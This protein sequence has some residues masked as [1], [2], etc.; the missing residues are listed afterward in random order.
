MDKHQEKIRNLPKF[1][2]AYLAS[3]TG[4]RAMNRQPSFIEKSGKNSKK[5]PIKWREFAGSNQMVEAFA[6]AVNFQPA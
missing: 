6:K 2:R 5:E 1:I 3:E 4:K